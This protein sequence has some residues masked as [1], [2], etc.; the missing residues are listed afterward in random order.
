[1][2][3]CGHALIRRD[4]L[5]YQRVG[6]VD[7]RAPQY[8]LRR[9]IAHSTPYASS[10]GCHL[11]HPKRRQPA[12]AHLFQCQWASTAAAST[13]D[14]GAKLP[15]VKDHQHFIERTRGAERSERREIAPASE[16]L[17]AAVRQWRSE[18]EQ[19]SGDTQPEVLNAEESTPDDWRIPYSILCQYYKPQS[20]AQTA[21]Y[22]H[23]F[24][25]RPQRERQRW[26]L[27]KP[28]IW[29]CP[30]LTMY[31]HDLTEY[32]HPR[33]ILFQSLPSEA[34][35]DCFRTIRNLAN[36]ILSVFGDEN[37][38]KDVNIEACHVALRFFYRHSFMVH[39]RALYMRMEYLEIGA[40]TETWNIMLGA[41]KNLANFTKFLQGMGRRGFRPDANTW[42]AFTKVLDS[43]HTRSRVIRRMKSLGVMNN[44]DVQRSI[45]NCM[46][47]H[48][49]EKRM[50]EDGAVDIAS[51]FS[52]IHDLYGPHWL[53][54]PAGN[55][56]LS[57]LIR[58][59]KDSKSA[60]IS[61]ALDVLARMRD[62][63]FIANH[64]TM[65]ILLHGCEWS[66][67][68]DILMQ[69]LVMFQKTWKLRPDDKGHEILFRYAWLHKDLNFLRAIWIS[70]CVK[71]YV[72]FSMQD[73]VV[74][75]VL[76]FSL[77]SL[78]DNQPIPFKALAGWFVLSI[79]PHRPSTGFQQ[80]EYKLEGEDRQVSQALLAL[81]S[82]LALVTQAIMP[83]GFL[84]VLRRALRIDHEWYQRSFWTSR[85][86]QDKLIKDGLRIRVEE[87]GHPH[88]RK[89]KF[90]RVGTFLGGARP[91]KKPIS[92]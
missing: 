58:S 84:G 27:Q 83:P 19:Q 26:P 8:L 50:Q 78:P 22:H 64:V 59:S 44:P 60:S 47:G 24:R 49:F 37:L 41:C 30:S 53:S 56:I 45:S 36:V 1:M 69:L 10:V 65:G 33:P 17:K 70:A 80:N 40:S 51:F 28:R 12:S 23:S 38:R 91:N 81:K 55:T 85:Q 57:K 82:N 88:P 63:G 5:S 54:T 4:R 77:L 20:G 74:Q 75:S 72:T 62:N 32:K 34:K 79:N 9:S 76:Q 35:D 87:R 68:R 18:E 13:D 11:I 14:G 25:R 92:S 90:L 73:R 89:V 42:V 46:I 21:R 16:L 3:A 48:H 86:V 29:D 61:R 71:G 52:E 7:K 66:R 67:K 6:K 43:V 31:I 39:A 2:K 15:V